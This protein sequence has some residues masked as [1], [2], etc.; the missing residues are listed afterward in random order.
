[1]EKELSQQNWLLQVALD[2]VEH[3]GIII[4]AADNNV[5]KWNI[6][7]KRLTGLSDKTLKTR[8]SRKYLKEARSL[9]A[10]TEQFDLEVAQAM[11]SRTE[12]SHTFKLLDG[13]TLE[14][15]VIPLYRDDVLVGRIAHIKDITNAG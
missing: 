8:D 11:Q 3:C 5:L 14:R 9:V 7:Y 12:I 15:K 4:I 10:N 1:M 6:E 2:S 13:R